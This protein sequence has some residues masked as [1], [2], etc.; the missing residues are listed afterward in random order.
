MIRSRIVNMAEATTE[1]S[2]II[3]LLCIGGQSSRMGSRKEL[4]PFPDG[5][6]A[7]E[8]AIDTIH[9][10]I[11]MANTIYISLHDESQLDG[12][13]FR[14]VTPARES[15]D[16]AFPSENNNHHHEH[17]TVPELKPLFDAKKYGDIGPA[18]GLLAAHAVLPKATFLMLGCD[19]PLLPP[20]ALQQLILE[21]EAPLTCFL[22]SEGFSE[23]L[24]AIW[25]PE[26]LEML[27]SNVEEGKNGLN[28][29][30]KMMRRKNGEAVKL[31]EPL[32]DE[33][34]TGCNTKEE[35]DAAME[36]IKNRPA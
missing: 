27:K 5:R 17:T 35:W 3:P 32:R 2:I 24:I 25:S 21:Y 14:L 34:I 12:I 1:E 13:Q 4:L 15:R 19:Y 8:H 20:T 29:V 36:V 33:W 30:V 31:V 9:D 18:A 11:P 28:R 22:N 16:T 6:L 10:A 7:F 23:P 26:A